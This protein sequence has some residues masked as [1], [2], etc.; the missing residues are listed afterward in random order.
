MQKVTNIRG[1]IST[2]HS[3]FGAYYDLTVT[4]SNKT[5]LYIQ[6]YIRG[7]PFLPL[8]IYIY[9]ILITKHWN[10]L[11]K[12]NLLKIEE[13]FIKKCETYEKHRNKRSI[14]C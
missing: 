7:I 2:T 12:S 11:D 14:Y 6:P 3:T 9:L 1:R 5:Q 13:G 4:M 8:R 10:V